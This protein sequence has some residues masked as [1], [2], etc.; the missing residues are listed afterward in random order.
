MFH[1]SIS[2]WLSYP[3]IIIASVTGVGGFAF[4]NP[5]SDG[6]M[7][8]NLRWFQ[9]AFATLNVVGGI[10]TSVNKFSQSASLVEKHSIA[11]VAYSKLYRAIDMEL[12]LD[13]AHR[14]KKSVADLVRSF[15]EHYDRLLDDSPDIPAKTI[16]QFQKQFAN[17]PRARP[18]VTNG[19]SPVV[20]GIKERSESLQSI[21]SVMLKW[22]ES[23]MNRRRSSED[24]V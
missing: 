22:K 2:D 9:I 16:I 20:K 7:P 23:V 15:R 1:K 10:L 13:P 19:L 11:S 8:E 4:M 18:E 12:T 17:D 6:D 21:K 24:S 5:N 14:D 3:S